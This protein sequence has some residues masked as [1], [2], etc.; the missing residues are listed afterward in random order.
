M[1]GGASERDVYRAE[2]STAPTQ[3]SND[4]VGGHC[5]T[6]HQGSADT[7]PQLLRDRTR[8]TS[9]LINY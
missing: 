2:Y 8:Q 6:A 3:P 7:V 4:T 5:R 1:T 9:V